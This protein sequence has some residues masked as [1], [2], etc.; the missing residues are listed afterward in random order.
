MTAS[1]GMSTALLLFGFQVASQ[2]ARWLSDE[3]ARG[4]VAATIHSVYPQPCYSSYRQEQLESL[5]VRLRADAIVGNQIHDSVY[6]Y[7]VASDA[8]DYVVEND[9]KPVRMT[10]VSMDCC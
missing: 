7:R 5:V 6:F 2:D 4:I 9:G 10:Q 8:C 1:L 3:Q